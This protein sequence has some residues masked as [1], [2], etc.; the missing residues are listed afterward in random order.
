MCIYI[1]INS[2]AHQVIKWE[3]FRP[4]RSSQV[5]KSLLCPRIDLE[6]RS[7]TTHHH[8]ATAKARSATAHHHGTTRTTATHHHRSAHSHA[9]H[10]PT[11]STA[12]VSVSRHHRPDI[13][14]RVEAQ[15]AGKPSGSG[16]HTSYQENETKQ[17]CQHSYS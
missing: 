7:T 10:R 12:V 11:H 2:F 9:H 15:E 17:G 8:W 5:A 4:A 16:Q 1:F 6:A 14:H 13:I 3:T